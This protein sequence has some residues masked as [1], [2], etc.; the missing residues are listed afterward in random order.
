[1]DCSPPGSSV[2]GILQARILEWVAISY[3]RGSSRPRDQTHISRFSA[4]A[5][6]FFTISAT[7]WEAHLPREPPQCGQDSEPGVFIQ[8]QA[9]ALG[10]RWGKYT[11]RQHRVHLLA[12]AQVRPPWIIHL[13]D[14]LR[15]LLKCTLS[16]FVSWGLSRVMGHRLCLTGTA[17][18]VP[19]VHP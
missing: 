6:G 17:F 8:I 19:P 12:S 9:P 13:W 5:G 18:P 14:Q 3:S 10:S 7:K 4:L 15:F 16:A 2:H 1:M 11:H